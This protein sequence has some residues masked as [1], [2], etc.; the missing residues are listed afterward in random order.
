MLLRK[1]GLACLFLAAILLQSCVVESVE[2][3]W[4]KDEQPKIYVNQRVI[5]MFGTWKGED[6]D[7]LVISPQD[8]LTEDPSIRLVYQFTV[9]YGRL[10]LIRESYFLDLAMSGQEGTT[11]SGL[12]PLM[13]GRHVVLRIDSRQDGDK[14]LLELRA[15]DPAWLH[16]YLEQ[17]AGELG[18][19]MLAQVDDQGEV[20]FV[21][22]RITGS[23]A[24]WRSFIDRHMDA[25]LFVEP[26]VL[27]W[28]GSH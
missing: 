5:D 20:E 12:G 18:H 7:V 28:I 14:R 24:Q 6:G 17:H 9:L 10:A 26:A 13:S 4:L 25:G 22:P 8:F 11:G 27:E 16:D 23:T 2:P 21:Y 15:L 1:A 19:E 3:L